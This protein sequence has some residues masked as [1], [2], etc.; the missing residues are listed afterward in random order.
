M[1]REKR[2]KAT[3]NGKIEKNETMINTDVSL[4][5]NKQTYEKIAKAAIKFPSKTKKRRTEK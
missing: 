4:I 2:E 5:T 1:K 3:N